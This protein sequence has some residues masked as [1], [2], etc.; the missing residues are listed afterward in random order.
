MFPTANPKTLDEDFSAAF[1]TLELVESLDLRIIVP[2]HGAPFS[3]QVG[4]LER[5]RSRL[6]RL[7]ADPVRNGLHCAKV[8]LKYRL[9]DDRR[10]SIATVHAMFR[11]VPT[12]AHA[13]RDI[14]LPT[15][16]LADR[17]ME[18]L[19]K[20]GAARREGNWLLDA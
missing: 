8:L 14:G 13:N 4:A 9:L 10:M 7:A 2:G 1:E 3:D 6:K 17:T 19:D 12:I 5:V 16:V 15:Q 20:V 11:D 18:A